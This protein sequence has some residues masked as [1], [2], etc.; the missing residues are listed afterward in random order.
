MHK[1]GVT[2]GQR[3]LV[4]D[5]LVAT[6]GTAEASSRLLSNTEVEI[7]GCLFCIELVGLNGRSRLSPHP[8]VSLLSY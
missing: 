3:V 7:V 8:V 5:D 4:V 6:G 1:Y 2:K